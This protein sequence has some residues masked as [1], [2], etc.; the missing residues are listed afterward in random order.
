M[1]NKNDE[2]QIKITDMSYDG[3]GIGKY[4]NFPIFVKG[5]II[6]DVVLCGITKVNKN[7][8][9]ARLIKIIENSSNRIYPKCVNAD[10]CGG[11]QIAQ[12]EYDAQLQFKESKVINNLERI[13]KF[14]IFKKENLETKLEHKFDCIEI[15]NIIGMDC[16]WHYRNKTQ[17]PIGYNKDKELIAG[18]YASR[19]HSIIPIKKCEIVPN[20]FDDIIQTIKN[21][22]VSNNISAYDESSNKGIVRHILI[23]K[24][25]NNKSPEILVCIVIN[26]D[27]IKN[28]DKLVIELKKINGFKTLT[29]N[30]NKE[31][32]NVILG[33]ITKTICGTGYITDTING[34]KFRISSGSFFQVNHTQ[35]EKLYN[36]VLDFA[37]IKPSDIVWDLYCGAGSISL[38]LASK[39]KHVYGVEVVKDAVINARE[40]AEINSINNCDFIEGKAEEVAP[41]LTRDINYKPDLVVVDPPRKGCDQNCLDSILQMKPEKIVYVSCDSATLARDLRYLV[42]NGEYKLVKVQPVDMFP[43]TVH[44]ETVVLLSKMNTAK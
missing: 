27:E 6:G 22:M 2:I 35:T 39:A 16:P 20:E 31:N 37:D 29:I 15:N 12:M 43:H 33:R 26:A 4:D 32:T 1:L 42:D 18:F 28:I 34:L 19:T 11:C 44:V 25:L 23:R 8:A 13:G 3:L 5:A 24:G 17:I 21:F 40:N 10:K 36:V 14:K 7:L 30:I 41:K 38:F 9:Y